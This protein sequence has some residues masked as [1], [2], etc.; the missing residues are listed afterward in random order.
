MTPFMAQVGSGGNIYYR[1]TDTDIAVFS[2]VS[3]LLA[4]QGV[5]YNPVLALVVTWEN[6]P[7][8]DD[9]SLVSRLL[10]PLILRNSETF[11]TFEVEI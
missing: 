6:M 5:V 3:S 7:S 10:R 2:Q 4:D 9:A 11:K 8:P 1:Q